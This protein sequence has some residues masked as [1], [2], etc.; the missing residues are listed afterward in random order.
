MSQKEI[1]IACFG[2]SNTWGYDPRSYLGD[3]YPPEGRWPEVLSSLSGWTVLNWGENGREIPHSPVEFELLD[4]Q[5][6]DS[7]PL[8][9]LIIDLGTNDLMRMYPPS[10]ER[11]AE[12]MEV[13]LR[14][15]QEAHP[16]LP[17]LL[18]APGPM[19][20]PDDRLMDCSREL[21]ACYEAA[22]RK[23]GTDF[24]DSSILNL[25]LSYDGIHLSEAG[26]RSLAE[27]VFRKLSSRFPEC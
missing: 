13:L 19:D 27:A 2:A 22:A 10:A 6:R 25:D 11:T 4:G 24:L 15:V 14:H 7:W 5:I 9:L 3:R 20:I 21:G 26:H 16:T 18:I 17:L 1:R 12:R 8:D 23:T